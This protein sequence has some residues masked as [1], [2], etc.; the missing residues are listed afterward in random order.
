MSVPTAIISNGFMYVVTSKGMLTFKLEGSLLTLGNDA[1]AIFSNEIRIAVD[2]LG[3]HASTSAGAIDLANQINTIAGRTIEAQSGISSSRVAAKFIGCDL[4]VGLVFGL[5]G[6]AVATPV[7]GAVASVGASHACG[8]GLDMYFAYVD[9]PKPIQTMRVVFDNG[10]PI[11]TASVQITPGASGGFVTSTTDFNLDGGVTGGTRTINNADGPQMIQRLN[12]LLEPTETLE[13]YTV[14]LNDTLEGI[15]ARKGTTVELLV[16]FNNI[17]NPD[18]IYAGEPLHIPRAVQDNNASSAPIGTSIG[19]NQFYVDNTYSD[20]NVISAV[21]GVP[22]DIL[23]AVNPGLTAEMTVV[24]GTL[25]NLPA[26]NSSF[27]LTS[28]P[29]QLTTQTPAPDTV[30]PSA[31]TGIADSGGT[32]TVSDL[33]SALNED[34]TPFGALKS[35]SLTG[36]RRS[37]ANSISDTGNTWDLGADAFQTVDQIAQDVINGTAPSWASLDLAAAAA[38]NSHAAQYVPAYP[39]VLDLNGDGIKLTSY[40][41]KTVLFD[42]DHDGGS[43]EQTG[44]VSAQDGIVVM[45]LN[46]NGQIDDI[47]ETM[48][49]YF[50]GAVGTGGEAGTKPYANGFAALKSLDSNSDNQFTSAD[51][52]FNNVKVWQDANSD[53]VTDAGELKTLT[54]LNITAINLTPTAQSGLVNG[55]NEILASG[56]F[57]QNG[58]TQ[59]AQAA[60]FIANPYGQTLTAQ[61]TGTRI[62]AQTDSGTKATYVSHLAT[63]EVMDAATLNVANLTGNA[64]NDTL[65]G[66]A[67]ANWLA[68]G[69]G[70]DTFN[71][72]AGDDILLIDAEDL[73]ANIH[74]GA[75]NDIAQVIGDAGVTLNLAQAEIEAAIGG[76]G[77]DILIGGGRSSVFIRA[78]DGDDIV[79]GGAANDALSGENG[80]DLIDGG[81]GNDILRGGR[82][83]DQL[84][85]G[86]GDDLLFSGQDDDRLS[87]GSGND[88][89]K[90]EQGDDAID[91][92]DGID[93]AEFSG[94]FSDYRITKLTDI[95]YRVVDTKA[96]RDG[97]DMLTGVEKLS[98]ADV[99]GVDITLDNPF[100]TGIVESRRWWDGECTNNSWRDAA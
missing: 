48:S 19:A 60:N 95:S 25:V 5:A 17:P 89:L 66:D 100:C 96:G 77:D 26:A 94:S 87:G 73:Q 53:G 68:G 85:G 27:A 30:N 37:G 80:A 61:G 22:V 36:G 39:L 12:K 52:A 31:A 11:G 18:L 6:S 99:S 20:L 90:G 56:T 42:I 74:G 32:W 2:L 43:K 69:Q 45:D 33:V 93:I 88:V 10:T 15:A 84:M 83:Q 16:K 29:T 65:T 82:G 34:T 8:I 67:G 47:S 41:E 24:P 35:D 59:Q 54:E 64:G 98:F 23:V 57:T 46:G 1:L 97:A 13:V 7:V 92:G 78:N 51:T 81:A 3:G 4:L 76:R 91:G 50:N 14:K 63:G 55:G 58:S 40:A 79:I 86:A 21:T 44:W 38:G 49:E 28:N 71:A 62:D 72:G 9:A 75:G 70:A